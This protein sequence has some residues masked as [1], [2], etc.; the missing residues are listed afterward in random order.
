MRNII[1]FIICSLLG[2]SL[3]AKPI[4]PVTA[5]QVSKNFVFSTIQEN[6]LKEEFNSSDF[7]V[8]DRS[9]FILGT[10]SINTFYLIKIKSG[11]MLVSAD[12]RAYTIIGYSQI[13]NLVPSKQPDNFK[14]WL[15]NVSLNIQQIIEGNTAQTPDIKIKRNKYLSLDKYDNNLQQEEAEIKPLIETKWNQGYP[16]NLL[17]PYD[18]DAKQRTITGC[19]ATAMAQIIKYHNYPRFGIGSGGYTHD[20]YGDL[21]VNFEEIEFNAF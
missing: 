4:N 9:I 13:D 3:F 1:V 7:K 20:K 11:W 18:D 5:I 10:D 19:V 21:W 8:I 12:D 14:M 17:C 15:N 16:F 6:K 2:I